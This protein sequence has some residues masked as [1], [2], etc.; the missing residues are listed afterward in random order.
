MTCRGT[1]SA[2]AHPQPLPAPAL[3]PQSL[4]APTKTLM[5]SWHAPVPTEPTHAALPL[6]KLGTHL[7]RHLDGVCHVPLELCELP[8]QVAVYALEHEPLPAQVV[9]LLAQL[10]VVRDAL[11]VLDV[12]LLQ[13]V[14]Q[15]LYP[16]LNADVELLGCVNASHK[17]PR[18]GKQLPHV[19]H[20]L[21]QHLRLAH[22]QHNLCP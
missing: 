22:L 16:L 8:L 17:R 4:Y 18:A 9:D 10:L 2:C 11:V 6:C 3:L 19:P 13:T 21:V 1:C 15:E 12:C 5:C 14:L 7:V 20:L